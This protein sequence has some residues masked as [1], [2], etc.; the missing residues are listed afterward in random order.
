MKTTLNKAAPL[1]IGMI[2]AGIPVNLL[3]SPGVGKSDLIKA[4]AKKLN[5]FLIDVR[6]STC[7]PCDLTGL[8]SIE[9]GRS[10]WSPNTAFP[11][12]TDTIPAGYDGW[13]L[14]LDE[15][16]NAPMA[17]QAAA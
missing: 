5:L 7:D 15:I 6:L 2:Q 12:A 16:T 10:V 9:N 3:A 8:P 11:L 17:V 1:V 13:L 14:F 4:V